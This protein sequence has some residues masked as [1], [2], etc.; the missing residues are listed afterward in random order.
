MLFRSREDFESLWRG[1]R[2]QY[3][4]NALKHDDYTTCDLNTCINL[5][6]ADKSELSKY[7]EEDGKTIK[8]PDTIFMSWDYDCNVACITCR[9][10]IIKNNESTLHSLQSIE[11]SVLEACKNA[12]LFYTSG[13]GDPFGS[14]YA[15][16]IIKK[17]V[18]INPKIRFLIHTNG[19]LCNKKICDE[20]NIADKIKDITFSIHA[21]CKETYDKIVRY[22]N[23]DKVLQNLE[24]ISSLKTEGKI[25]SICL[26]FVVHKLNY[27]DMPNFVRMAEKF[28]SVAS[29]RYYR[30]WANNTEYKYE[31]M[32]IFEQAH[33]EH[34]D[35][36]QML[37]DSIFDSPNCFLDPSLR[38]LRENNS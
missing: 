4:R 10:G 32:A 27:K 5:E 22:G 33:P 23:F 24:W 31:D 20:L 30:Q 13:N 21:A 14:S 37:Q 38:L 34:S 19:V 7:Y 1:G 26:V 12:K 16:N 18:E 11:S 9:N 15:R 3:L 29:F 17:V 6:L 25:E 2:A 36:I 8:M 28:N 35:F